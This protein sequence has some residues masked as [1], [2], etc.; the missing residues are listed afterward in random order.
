MSLLSRLSI[1]GSLT[2]P[3]THSE[4]IISFDDPMDVL[5]YKLFNLYKK[6]R[7]SPQLTTEVQVILSYP[8]YHNSK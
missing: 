7:K 4:D 5:K 3:W 1:D 2:E 8:S 6:W